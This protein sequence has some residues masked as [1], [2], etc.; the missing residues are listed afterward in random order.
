MKFVAILVTERSL[1]R[2]VRKFA[3]DQVNAEGMAREFLKGNGC[4]QGDVF[5]VFDVRP[6]RVATV[7]WKE[8]KV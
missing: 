2:P 4:V 8:D 7:E 3:P 6:K 5:E 1:E